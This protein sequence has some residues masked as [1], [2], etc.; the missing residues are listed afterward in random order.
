MADTEELATN[1]EG[2][3]DCLDGAD[4]EVADNGDVDANHTS[5]TVD[6]PVRILFIG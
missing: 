2:Q 4:A 1:S 6:D 3:M 5:S